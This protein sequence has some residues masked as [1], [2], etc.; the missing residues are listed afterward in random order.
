MDVCNPSRRAVLL[1]AAAFAAVA[2]GASGVRAN[3]DFELGPPVNAKVPDIGT[4]ADQTGKPRTLASLMGDK[5]LVLFFFRSVVWCPFC[6]AQLM[7]LNAGLKDIER[8]GYK[9]AGLT[10]ETSDVQKEFSDRRKIGFT[11][12]ADPGSKIIDTYKLRDPQ[13]PKGDFAYGVPRPIIFILDKNGVIKAKL[14]EETYTKRPPLTL[15]LETIDRIAK[16]TA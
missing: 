11:L 13:Y 9:V 14:Y 12:L 6:Q 2:T 8:R 3:P 16:G 15:V 1:G 10:Y 4:P 5:G 7:E